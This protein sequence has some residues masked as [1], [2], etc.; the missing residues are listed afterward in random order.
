[1]EAK[2]FSV[3]LLLHLE[4]VLAK[5]SVKQKLA[6]ARKTVF[7]NI[8]RATNLQCHQKKSVWVLY[9][10]SCKDSSKHPPVKMTGPGLQIP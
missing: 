4:I 6:I 8:L 2:Q 7:A 10:T 1:M 3:L 5:A 9:L